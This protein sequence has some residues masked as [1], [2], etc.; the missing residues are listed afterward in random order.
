VCDIS[1]ARVIEPAAGI[2]DEEGV[3]TL[4][5]RHIKTSAIVTASM[6]TALTGLS[7]ICSS[8]PA[9][10]EEGC[11]YRMWL[12]DAFVYQSDAERNEDSYIW[13]GGFE[14]AYEGL[15]TTYAKMTAEPDS[16]DVYRVHPIEKR[17]LELEGEMLEACTNAELGCA[18]W[19]N[20]D[21]E[22]LWRTLNPPAPAGLRGID[23]ESDLL[24]VNQCPP[25]R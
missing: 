14:R 17:E 20:R 2:F 25:E 4:G 19:P 24:L 7:A 23:V 10:F 15:Q 9:T 22:E 11:G 12:H 8:D 21:S 16:D 1:A 6:L 3:T 18:P 5:G 13:Q